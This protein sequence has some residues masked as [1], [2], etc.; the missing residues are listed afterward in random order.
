MKKTIEGACIGVALTGSFCTFEKVFGW[1]PALSARGAQLFPIMSNHASTFDTRFFSAEQAISRLESICGRKCL[2]NVV[3]VEPIGPQRM[4]DLL[5]ILPCTGNT[6]AKLAHGIADTAATMAAKSQ[7]RNE[8]PVLLALST[9]DGLGSNAANIGMLMARKHLFFVPYGQDDPG[10]KP[11]SLLFSCEM[12]E[13]S[14][15]YALNERQIQP[16]LQADCVNIHA[17]NTKKCAAA[18]Q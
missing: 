2:M 14:V 5:L 17:F 6:I 15:E 11:T 1:L 18:Q 13:K 4:L 9:N 12:L 8:R 7:L 16:I 10:E 3:D